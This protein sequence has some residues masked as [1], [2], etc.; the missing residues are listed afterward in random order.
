MRAFV[1]AVLFVAFVAATFTPTSVQIIN[2][3][4]SNPTSLWR[5]E[6]NQFSTWSDEQL[7]GLCGTI[8][9]PPRNSHKHYNYNSEPGMHFVQ[10]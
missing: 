7:R 2:E 8:I 9:K 4:N 5:A 3:V 1:F 6:H 10:Y